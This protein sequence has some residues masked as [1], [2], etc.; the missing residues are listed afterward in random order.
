M[1]KRGVVKG[2]V[3]C[4]QQMVTYVNLHLDV[5]AAPLAVEPAVSFLEDPCRLFQPDVALVCGTC[6]RRMVAE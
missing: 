6:P 3:D 4:G 5:L 2:E 1:M